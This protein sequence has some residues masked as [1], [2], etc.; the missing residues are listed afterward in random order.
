M[1]SRA[2]AWTHLEDVM[3]SG[4][5][6]SQKDLLYNPTALFLGFVLFG[7][8]FFLLFGATPEAYG[9]SQARGQI[10]ATAAGLCHSHSNPRSEL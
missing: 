6:H 2:P 8:F 4:M 5:S 9:G 7:F 1:L 10:G 3:L